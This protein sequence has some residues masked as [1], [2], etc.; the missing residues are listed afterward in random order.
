MGEVGRCE[1]R[2]EGVRVGG[3]DAG[4]G[5]AGRGGANLGNYTREKEEKGADK[6][7]V[8]YIFSSSLSETSLVM[9]VSLASCTAMKTSWSCCLRRVGMGV[10]QASTPCASR[11]SCS[12][13]WNSMWLGRM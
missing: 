2:C 9:V 5:G 13:I 10:Q 3:A 1:C 11:G 7:Q 8:Y 12:D 6:N 4:A